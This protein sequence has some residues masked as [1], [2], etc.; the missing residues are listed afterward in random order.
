MRRVSEKVKREQKRGTGTGADYRPW[1]QVGEFGSN[2]TAVMAID[3]KTGR[4]VQLLS[5]AEAKV[6]YSLRWNDSNTDIREQFPLDLDAT[7]TIS[8][9]YGLSHPYSDDG[10][11][12]VMTTDFLVDRA[13]K[14]IAVSVKCDWNKVNKRDIAFSELERMYWERKGVL[15][16]R[17]SGDAV[18]S[19]TFHNLRAITPFFNA[20]VFP[21]VVSVLK[22]MIARKQVIVDLS[23]PL[24]YSVL[25][26]QFREPVGH[27]IADNKIKGLNPQVLIGGHTV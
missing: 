8:S 13:E 7:V 12:I 6:W 1:I 19:N 24:N 2:G 23:E 18:N 16:Q 25:L 27:F 15:F 9:R 4:T 14:Q 3:W 21:D 20:T 10:H 11:P 26:E 5:Q 17:I 22:H